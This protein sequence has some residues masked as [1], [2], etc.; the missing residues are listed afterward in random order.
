[1]AHGREPPHFIFALMLTLTFAFE[2]KWG[3]KCQ[4]ML[5]ELNTLKKVPPIYSCRMLL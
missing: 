1:M 5:K 3:P 2:L 4:Y